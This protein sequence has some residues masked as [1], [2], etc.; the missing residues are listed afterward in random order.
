M[1][2]DGKPV[3]HWGEIE[4]AVTRS[5]GRP[6]A[7]T[8]DAG[9]RA[10]G[11][12]R[13]SAQGCPAKTP[14]NEPA[15]VWRIGARPLRPPVVGEV[16]PGMPAAD[17]GIQPRDR[18]VALNGQPIE[19]WD[20]LAETISTRAGEALTLRIERGGSRWTSP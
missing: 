11:G 19:T 3:E 13:H 2:I 16:R 8:I 17:A 1:A 9:R 20:E 18:I 6:L 15:E 5:N 10:A 14:F 7:L 12:V 4:E